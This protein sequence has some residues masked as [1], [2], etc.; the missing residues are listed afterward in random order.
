MMKFTTPAMASEPYTAEAPPVTTSMRSIS[1]AGI[2]LM[3]GEGFG[4]PVL[5]SPTP[6]RRPSTSTR[7]RCGP[8]PR[9]FTVVMP[10]GLR[11]WVAVVAEVGAGRD[12][13]R[14]PVH[15]VAG[16]V[17]ALEPKALGRQ[18]Q[19]RARTGRVGTRD[20]RSGHDDFCH[21][22]LR[23]A[24]VPRLRPCRPLRARCWRAALALCA[25]SVRDV[26]CA[27]FLSVLH[28]CNIGRPQS[29][30]RVLRPYVG[31]PLKRRTVCKA[32]LPFASFL[33]S[34][35]AFLRRMLQKTH[36]SGLRS[37]A[38]RSTPRT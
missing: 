30:C 1:A 20:A 16:I 10:P 22:I 33:R 18:A 34:S 11:Q 35:G 25:K 8:R 4:L 32:S 24:Q 21:R 6:S 13:L 19:D 9:R 15:Q 27:C 29:P 37:K 12:L 26:T 3:S 38:C 7:V 5:G 17:H 31:N 28:A 2:W 14:Q 36:G 23:T